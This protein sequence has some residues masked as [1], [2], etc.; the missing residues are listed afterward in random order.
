ML[1]WKNARAA[2]QLDANP[3]VGFTSF[4]SPALQSSFRVDGGF[5]IEK[6][7]NRASEL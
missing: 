1:P 6:G 3:G 5:F 4:L 7:V 2:V